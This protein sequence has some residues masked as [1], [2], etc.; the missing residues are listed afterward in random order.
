MHP[1]TQTAFEPAPEIDPRHALSGSAR[2]DPAALRAA[3]A[4]HGTPV[5][6]LST[7]AVR[8]RYRALRSALPGVELHYAVKALP[9][10]A[11]I[12]ELA[13]EGSS[14]DVASE[15]ELALLRSAGVDAA[16]CI[17]AHPV[18][19]PD[20]VARSVARGCRTFVFDNRDELSK[21]EPFRGS[22]DL[23]LR[24]SFPNEHAWCDLSAKFG[25]D[26]AAAAP[27]LAAAA[28]A[29]HRVRGLSFHVGSQVTDPAAFV[30]AIRECRRIVDVARRRGIHS[31][32]TLDIGGGFPVGYTEP[33]A[34][35]AD[36]CRRS[37]LPCG[38]PSP[39]RA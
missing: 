30:A 10:A 25:A 8:D 23:L 2:L 28:H 29:G 12:A 21:L 4:A 31:L 34:A 17:H 7:A 13:A 20:D 14:F 9:H 32:D 3:A 18:K 15:G 39:R 22:V 26:P 24:V 16:R 11:V 19:R 36:F 27:L 37:E 5:L 6:L 33:V 35:I 1:P 38:S